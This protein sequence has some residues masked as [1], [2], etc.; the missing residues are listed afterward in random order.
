MA[1]SLS[2]S[3]RPIILKITCEIILRK[4]AKSREKDDNGVEIRILFLFQGKY[5]VI[6]KIHYD[7]YVWRGKSRGT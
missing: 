6:D 4:K 5:N 3:S 1:T 2:L 7:D